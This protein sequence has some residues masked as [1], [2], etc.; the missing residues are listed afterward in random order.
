MDSLLFSAVLIV[1]PEDDQAFATIQSAIDSAAVGD[2]V[3]VAPGVYYENL[4]YLG[5]DI[6]VTSHYVLEEN[7]AFIRETVIDGNGSGACVV[8]NSGETRAAVLNGFTLTNG[9]GFFWGIH[10]YTGGGIYIK[11]SSPTI[12]NCIVTRNRV[13]GS[14]SSGGGIYIRYGD[15]TYLSNVTVRNNL[16]EF[17]GGGIRIT[18]TYT[19][20]FDS[21]RRCN[22][23]LNQAGFVNDFY[24]HSPDSTPVPVY[25]DTFT[26]LNPDGYLRRGFFT[27][28]EVLN[29]KV[30]PVPHDLYV[31]P[32]GDN[33]NTGETPDAPLKNIFYALVKIAADRDHSRTIHLL[34]G[35]YSAAT[36]GEL[37]PLNMR[38]YVSLI[39]AGIDT[40][41]ISLEGVMTAGL[42]AYENEQDYTIGHMT[43][44]NL[45]ANDQFFGINAILVV[46]N[47]N[48]LIKNIKFT[49]IGKKAIQCVLHTFSPWIDTAKITIEDCLFTLNEGIKA[50]S[51]IGHQT[52]IVRNCIFTYN[53]PWYPPD[54][55]AVGGAISMSSHRPEVPRIYKRIENC[56]FAR[57]FCD[58]TAT[59]SGPASID[60]KDKVIVDIVNCTFADNVSTNYANIGIFGMGTEVRIVNSILWG[61]DPLE[62]YLDGRLASEEEPVTVVLKNNIIQDG[63]W[64]I[65]RI[66]NWN[67]E[68][69]EDNL[70]LNPQFVDSESDD[71]RLAPES[72]AIDA[73]TPFFVWNGDT[74][75]D[76]LPEQYEGNAPDLGAFEFPS[77]MAV[78]GL[79]ELPEVFRLYQNYPNPANPGTVIRF[80]LPVKT[81]V[82]L[83]IFDLEGR[84][85]VTL[86]D[87]DVTAGIQAV[88]WNGTDRFGRP[89]ASGVYI[90]RIRAGGFVQSKKMVL[91]K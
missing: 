90:Y 80:E 26:V 76:L 71:Y 24:F 77:T 8:F 73:G 64:G 50:V 10:T 35:V 44:R 54:W 52:A 74:V 9:S 84:R 65:G 61:N 19:V 55:Y 82:N 91:M 41:I 86:I 3:L 70:D 11:N 49:N 63:E 13:F 30:D 68:W 60:I 48:L 59:L 81:P 42:F 7:P 18:D 47:I 28:F 66:G 14:S 75:V 53:T 21:V 17:L 85:I 78:A 22:V 40:T 36:N 58:N 6:Y 87:K 69:L 83:S 62:I 27:V 34:P 39:G 79:P 1:D 29:G 89:L 4:N 5:K 43:I 57:N 25:L 2:T 46:Q 23:Y 56:L 33:T 16:S 38:S 45:S 12:M 72:E 20:E 37:F 31:S 15:G 51:L 67:I 32:G 88:T